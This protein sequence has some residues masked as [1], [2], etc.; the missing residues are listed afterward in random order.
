[1]MEKATLRH[2]SFRQPDR[3]VRH[4]R[5]LILR[6]ARALAPTLAGGS[7]AIG[8]AVPTHSTSLAEAPDPVEVRTDV[9][10]LRSGQEAVVVVRSPSADSIELVSAN[11]VDRYWSR[12]PRLRALVSGDFGDPVPRRRYAERRQGV[13]LDRLMKP[14][15]ISVCR[16]GHC[17]EFHHEFE[18]RLPEHNRR[19][20]ALG[21]GWNS[22][23]ARRTVRG[24]NEGPLI[25]EALSSGVFF[26]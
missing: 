3:L 6:L 25:R 19:T 15:T 22:V 26:L 14:A 1:M 4:S 13:L 16:Q 17:R 18:V 5:L 21:G 2:S 23:F 9:P 11:G 20:V 24:R 12:G 7:A 8:C 10:V